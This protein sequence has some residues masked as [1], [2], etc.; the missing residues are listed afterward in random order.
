MFRFKKIIIFLCSGKF[1]YM[2]GE[3]VNHMGLTIPEYLKFLAI[4]DMEEA[5]ANQN[6]KK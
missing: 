3:R 6:S 4:K 1:K 2:L 5:E